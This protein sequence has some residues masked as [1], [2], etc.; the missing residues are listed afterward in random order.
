MAAPGSQGILSLNIK[1]DVLKHSPLFKGLKPFQIKRAILSGQ[2]REFNRGD[3]VVDQGNSYD[4]HFYVLLEGSAK[5]TH[6]DNDGSIHTLG[7]LKSGDLFGEIAEFSSRDRMARVTIEE[8]SRALEMQWN[9]IHQ[10]GRF[11]PRIAMRL[12]RNLS[13]VMGSRI[14]DLT[15]HADKSRDELTG[16]LTKSYFCEFFKQELKRSEYQDADLSLVLLD[17]EIS[18]AEGELSD[19]MHDTVVLALSRLIKQNLAATDILAR[20]DRCC[21]MLVLPGADAEAALQRVNGLQQQIDEQDIGSDDIQLDLLAAVT[22]INR[23]E[24]STLVLGRLQDKLAQ[25]REKRKNVTVSL[26]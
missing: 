19:D 10:L 2:I 17:M 11:H 8:S 9:S 14:V 25:L 5:A 20:W 6:R 23:G 4:D 26:V 21:F 1:D 22:Q 24:P 15:E 3:V 13:E 16:A 12:Y 7:Y 18:V